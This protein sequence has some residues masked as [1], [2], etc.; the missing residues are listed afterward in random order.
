MRLPKGGMAVE[1]ALSD[2]CYT[3]GLRPAKVHGSAS[4]EIRDSGCRSLW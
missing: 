4:L 3:F 1:R 2:P